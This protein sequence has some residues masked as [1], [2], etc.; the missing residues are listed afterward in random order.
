MICRNMFILSPPAACAGQYLIMVFRDIKVNSD[1]LQT[2]W[3]VISINSELTRGNN[4][5]SLVSK[6]IVVRSDKT[7]STFIKQA[8]EH[9][10]H[11]FRQ[12]GHAYPLQQLQLLSHS[13]TVQTVELLLSRDITR[14]SFEFSQCSFITRTFRINVSW[15]RFHAEARNKLG[16]SIIQLGCFKFKTINLK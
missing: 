11:L 9:I 10:L 2:T 14:P 5:H 8:Q 15:Q 7:V 6:R 13:H 4:S 1:T 12:C 3:V 16:E